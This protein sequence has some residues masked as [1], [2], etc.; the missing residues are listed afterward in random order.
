MVMFRI[1]SVIGLIMFVCLSSG[2]SEERQTLNITP[3][4]LSCEVKDGVFHWNDATLIEVKGDAVNREII[5]AAFEGSSLPVQFAE[6]L[7]DDN[8]IVL[9]V[10]DRL[11]GINSPE[12]YVLEVERETVA[13]K[14]LS[15]AGLFYGIKT[16]LQ[17]GRAR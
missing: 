17:L 6:T 16:L 12:G 9:Q 2:C 4:P 1:F 14:A 10:V 8:V 13:L 15:D 5:A 7:P 3:C 11:P